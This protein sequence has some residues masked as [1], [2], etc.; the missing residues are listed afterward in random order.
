ML[1]NEVKSQCLFSEGETE[2]THVFLELKYQPKTFYVFNN[3]V[4]HMVINYAQTRYLMSVEFQANKHKLTY[5][6]LL[7]EMEIA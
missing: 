4:P 3:Q 7:K 1:L 6:Q 5:E 2:A